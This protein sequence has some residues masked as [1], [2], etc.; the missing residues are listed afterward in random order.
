MSHRDHEEL[1]ALHWA[2]LRGHLDAVRLLLARGA[3]PNNIARRREGKDVK[4]F[5]P[6]GKMI[7]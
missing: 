4:Q 1:C 6:L 7:E 5:T 2:V 3:N